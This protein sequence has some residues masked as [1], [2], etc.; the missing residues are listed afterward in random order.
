MK[1]SIIVLTPLGLVKI[2]EQDNVIKKLYFTKEE[3]DS[4]DNQISPM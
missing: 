3:Q 2:A 1:N 4:E